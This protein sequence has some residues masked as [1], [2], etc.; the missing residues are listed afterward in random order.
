MFRC[1]FAD[2]TIASAG[3]DAQYAILEVE[4]VHGGQVWQYMGVP[5]EIWYRF[6]R[7]AVPDYFFHN[8][9]KGCYDEKRIT[10]DFF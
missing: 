4:F 5:E 8:Y 10:S 2:L 3:Y 1:N 6:K 7:E 9:I